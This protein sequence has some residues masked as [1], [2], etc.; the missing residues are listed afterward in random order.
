M[1]SPRIIDRKV[2]L[3]T[4]DQLVREG[5]H[6]VLARIFAARG[7][8]ARSE[9][10]DALAALAPPEALLG[11]DRAALLLADAIA[12]KKR[13][14]IVADYDCDGATA[15]ALGLRA[16]KGFGAEA[17]FIVPDRFRFGYGLTPEI[18]AQAALRRPD[19]IITVD[20][21]IASI[22][23]VDAAKRL[24]IGV[25]IT[26]HHLPGA[27]L[28]RA[29]AIV[30]PN[31]R[32]CGFPSKNLAGVG[33]MFYVMLALR[34]ELRRRGAFDKRI[35]PNLADLLD[36]VA[37]GTVA[38]VVR[39]DQN[40]R[41]LVAQGLKR[42]RGGRVQPGVR[43]LLAVAGRD[44]ARATSFDLGFMAGP[45]LNAAGRLED[46][47]V[48]IECL[49]SDDYGKALN[50]AR[51]LDDLNRERR[52]I[53]ADMQVQ[54]DALLETIDV[55]DSCT[56]ALFD[57]AWHQGVIGILAGRL[58]DRHH[59]PVVAFARGE[60]GELKGSGRSIAGVHLRDALDLVARREPGLIARFGGHAAAAGLSLRERDFERFSALFEE[61]VRGLIEPEELEH[62]VETDGALESAYLSLDMA[63]L[64][65][66]QIWGQGFAQPLFC[67]EFEVVNQ[68]VVGE[69]HL[70][71]RLTRA[72]RT[73]EAMR[74]QSRD[75]LPAKVRAAYRLTVNEFNG[76]QSLQLVI[77][78]WQEAP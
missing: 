65:E 30:N 57:P 31:Q 75:S 29:A 10:D 9:L 36:L 54:A 14:L 64:L 34:A 6:P 55:R 68:R 52:S 39:L 37:L 76:A 62:V 77:E 46:M 78:Y 15:C 21:G 43:A 60:G 45:R 5:V 40:N 19:I 44:P 73:I 2:S 42:I 58:K 7:V 41:V 66:S 61:V 20:N 63:R 3:R 67:D 1:S 26:D 32:G 23:G 17:G 50:L 47:S 11:A 24:G 53:E 13:L 16:L 74:F 4:H 25:V 18:V 12:A 8:R 51:R 33:V 38:D 27:E 49:V 28:P 56:I 69:R 72:G 71:L 22:E 70:K 48:G 59:R 35:E